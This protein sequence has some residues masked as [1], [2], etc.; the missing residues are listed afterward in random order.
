[1]TFQTINN[2]GPWKY[3]PV[4]NECIVI[5]LTIV[6]GIVM[7]FFKLFQAEKFVPH[8]TKFVFYCALPLLVLQGL[9]VGTDFYNDSFLWN[10]ICAFLILRAI[11]LL[12]AFCVVVRFNDGRNGLGEVAVLWL[13]LT[14]IST[15]ILGVPISGAVFGD[16]S[17]GQTYGILAGV[18]SFIFQLPFQLFFLECH[19]LEMEYFD[20]RKQQEP[21]PEEPKAEF[22]GEEEKWTK[23]EAELSS[24][25]LT[26]PEE[27]APPKEESLETPTNV[28]G[29][30]DSKS[31]SIRPIH[32]WFQ[33]A[34]RSDVWKK[35]LIKVVQNPVL[36]GI[37]G[38]FVLSLST[39]GPRFL[40]PNGE[41][42]VPGL[43]WF[44]T[45]T[46]WLGNCV[47]PVSLFSMGIWM[48]SQGMRLF[49][50]STV[51]MILCMVS[52]L[53]IV[54][55]VM[56][57]LAKGLNLSDEAGRAAVLIAALPI[58]QASF[59]LGNQYKIGEAM[60]SENVA[61]GTALILPT[62]LIW[63]IVL[64][65]WNLFPIKAPH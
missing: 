4:L 39:V 65:A 37:A 8:S 13:T 61:L 15:V 9:G 19:Q 53:I 44:A 56:V 55:L 32:L 57:G 58:S 51:S 59:S 3:L 41:D 63:N 24:I 47:S 10:F 43:A 48:Q 17:K 20:L 50:I 18:S 25:V 14:W 30:T 7:G 64:D 6:F 45:T 23:E 62:V 16:P 52:K 35:I 11:A 60:L 38:G 42:F 46:G 27:Q 5:L 1:M 49:K 22:R 29:S 33:F 2:E 21:D 26:P 34:Q 28:E 36:W 31:N 54:P 12:I 40:S